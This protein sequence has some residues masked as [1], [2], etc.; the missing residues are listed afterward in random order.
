M[1]NTQNNLMKCIYCLEEKPPE[2]YQNREHVIPQCLG[3][4]SPDNLILYK[5][6]CDDCNQY[7]G[8]KLELFLGR[9]SYESIERAKHGIE[10]KKPLKNKRRVKS[11]VIE[12]KWKGVIVEQVKADMPGEIG[13]RNCMQAGFFNK[14]TNE[15]KYFEPKDIPTAREL[16]KTG[17]DLKKTIW[18]FADDP[19]LPQLLEVLKEKGINIAAKDDLVEPEQPTGS[20]E[21]ESEVTIDRT[22]SRALSKIAFNYFAHI[23]GREIVLREEFNGIRQFIRFGE[24]DLKN[25]FAVN[26]APILHDDQKIQK[27]KA[28]ITQGH[29]I[30]VKWSKN[31][32]LSKVSPFN[33][34]TYAVLLCPNYKGIWFPIKSGHH[35]DLKNMEVTE[36]LSV[37]KRFTV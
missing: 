14:F 31:A 10:P 5:S 34:Y 32:I 22:I 7:F 26:V 16:E 2:K 35:F 25:Y 37:S 36:L 11:K 12:G 28:K 33:S 3:R 27:F 23:A 20:M 1:S 13:I 19:E 24:G 29:L 4:F 15:Y 18:M 8:D 9:D 30:N 17:Y 6:V 21:V